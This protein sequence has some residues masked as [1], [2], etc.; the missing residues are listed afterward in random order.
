LTLWNAATV[1][2]ANAL[3]RAASL[4]RARR[5][6]DASSAA[7]PLARHTAYHR[8]S[9]RRGLR[10]VQLLVPEGA[11]AAF[12]AALAALVQRC[13]PLLVML[14]AQAFAA[15]PRG[16]AMA[17]QGTL[18]ALDLVPGPCT[19]T[20]LDA[21]DALALELGLQPS[22][23]KDSRLPAH[24]AARA[25][26]GHAAFRDRLARLDPQ[27]LYQSALSRRLEL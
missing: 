25:L 12:V 20:F 19:T 9:G 13:E 18:V 7:F 21:L 23:A 4:R 22:V 27:R 8:L 3:F 1:K 16:L 11:R 10:E 26:P 17:G 2:A 6:Q 24:V 5:V 14:S 15:R